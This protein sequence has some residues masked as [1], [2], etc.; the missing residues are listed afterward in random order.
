MK[1]TTSWKSAVALGLLVVSTS[2]FAVTPDDEEEKKCIR[3]KFRDFVPE[4]KAEVNPG[5]EISFHISHNA[6]PLHITA[7]AKGLKLAV[8]VRDRNTFFEAHAQLPAELI[9]TF[10]RINV[11]AKAMEGECVAHDGWLIK[12]KPKNGDAVPLAAPAKS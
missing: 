8:K 9:N 10:A 5:S 3:P 11:Q 12:I 7:E 2:L 4:A 1:T 6:D